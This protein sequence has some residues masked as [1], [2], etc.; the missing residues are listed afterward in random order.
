MEGRHQLLESCIFYLLRIKQARCPPLAGTGQA[1]ETSK[2]RLDLGQIC[3]ENC[4]SPHPSSSHLPCQ[5]PTPRPS[6]LYLGL[7]RY[8]LSPIW[9]TAASAQISRLQMGCQVCRTQISSWADRLTILRAAM[10]ELICSS[11]ADHPILLIVL[12]LLYK[13]V[14][15][16]W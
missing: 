15:R 4:R 14:V 3:Q 16:K 12:P 6:T 8:T 7:R 2:S 5:Q 13:A 9:F 11:T 10:Q 1:T